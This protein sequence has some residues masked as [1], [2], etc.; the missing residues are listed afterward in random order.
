M[1]IS[2]FLAA[3]VIANTPAG[4]QSLIAEIGDPVETG[5]NGA[6]TRALATEDGWYMGVGTN[7]DFHI[8][9]LTQTGSGLNDWS[10]DSR[11]W[12]RGTDHGGRLPRGACRASLHHR[13]IY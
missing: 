12:V 4:A 8:G 11:D 9:A 3:L 10:Y 1:P 7:G 2:A 6:W 5:T 13:G